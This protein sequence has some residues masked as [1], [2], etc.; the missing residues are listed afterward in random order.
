MPT[1]LAANAN[2]DLFLDE[3]GVVVL[4]SD[5]AATMQACAHAVKAQFGEM[6]LAI[7]Q[8]I[9]YLQTI[10]GGVQN[11]QLFESDV[12]AAILAVDGVT[13]IIAFTLEAIGDQLNYHVTI[14][15]IYGTGEISESI[16][17]G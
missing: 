12:R 14:R 15:T 8:G 4:Y 7:D 1:I 3:N 5:L 11:Y 6:V 16:I 10:W 2:N 9:P 17:N 13:E